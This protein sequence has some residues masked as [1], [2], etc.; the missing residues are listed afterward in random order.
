LINKP[1]TAQK[2]HTANALK[3]ASMN[4]FLMQTVATPGMRKAVVCDFSCFKCNAT[5]CHGNGLSW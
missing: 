3:W 5:G 2:N 1:E 4:T